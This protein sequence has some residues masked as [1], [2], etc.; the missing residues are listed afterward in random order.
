MMQYNFCKLNFRVTFVNYFVKMKKE[1]FKIV[2]ACIIIISSS[3]YGFGQI[4]TSQLTGKEENK[5]NTITT[6][7]PFLMIAPDARAGGMGDAGVASTPDANSNHWNAAKYAF[8]NKGMGFSVSYSPWLRALVPDINLA[9]L[10]GYKKLG[11]DQAIAVSLLYFSLGDIT[12]TDITG[13]TTGQFKPNEFAVDASFSRKLSESL[14]GAFALRYIRSDLTGRQF[15]SGGQATH[16]GQAIAADIS[17]YYRKPFEMFKQKNEIAAGINISN[18][19]NRISYTESIERDF[20]PINLRVGPALTMNLDKYNSLGFMVDLNKLL[21]PTPPQYLLDG[22]GNPVKD[23]DGKQVIEKG[24]DPNTSVVSGMFG[25]FS[26]APG[27]FKE[28]LHEI[29]YSCGVEYWYDKQFGVRAGYFYEH[30]TKGNRKFFT[31]GA[32]IKYNVFGLDFAYLIPTE[33]KNPLENTLRFSLLFDFEAFRE[34]N[35]DK[36]TPK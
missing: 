34:Q 2:L 13:N 28:E 14:S 22:A 35:K 5:L 9:Y 7:V 4:S 17:V 20:I 8:S 27:G 21:V 30:A 23:A 15:I 33:Q 36:D 6:A 18:I 29:T 19:G 3:F 31:L 10:S 1:I 16:P 26:D 12:F 25:S 32:G 24:K 11:K